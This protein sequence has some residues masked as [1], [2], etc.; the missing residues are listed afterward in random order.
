M[1]PNTATAWRE[2]TNL[3]LQIAGAIVAAS[4]LLGLALKWL[5]SRAIARW[6]KRTETRVDDEVVASLR[7]PIPVWTTLA[8]VAL[9]TR[10]VVVPEPWTNVVD[11]AI[12]VMAIVSVTLW[13]AGVGVRILDVVGA[14][15][16]D[17]EPVKV[18][19][20]ARHVVRIVLL[21]IGGLVVLGTLDISIAPLLTTLGIGGLAVA[22]ALKDTLEN[23]FAGIHVTLARGVR[24]GDFVR[25][26]T[27]DEGT[28]EDIGWRTTR[29]RLL[30]NS[31]VLVPNARLAQSVVTNHDLPIPEV[32]VVVEVGVHYAS[33][34]ERVQRI[35]C[36]VGADV[37]KETAGGVPEFEPFVRFH[38]FGESSV[39]FTVVLRAARYVDRYLV[40]H[41]FITRLH[42]RYAAER[43]VIPFPIRALNSD[44]ERLV[45]SPVSPVA[46]SA[47][48]AVRSPS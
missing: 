41:E 15:G 16:R 38:T 10:R 18:T 31:V 21:V 12:V 5:A 20:V 9:A 29:I 39:D 40:K 45:A 17:G 47:T 27:G 43:I 11:K 23:L 33:D 46:A 34:L 1:A 13:L 14:P 4:L 3:D 37:M 22:L 8:G 6:A 42:K 32:V 48:G 28:V 35:T 7:R 24:V 2:V 30:G 36:E 44:Q 19:G 26:E 25:L